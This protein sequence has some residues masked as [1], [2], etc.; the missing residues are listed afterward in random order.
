MQISDTGTFENR[1]ECNP[2]PNPDSD[3]KSNHF[4][5]PNLNPKTDPNPNIIPNPKAC[6][7]DTNQEVHR[8]DDDCTFRME[9]AMMHIMS[10]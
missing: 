7:A 6:S 5:N 2:N 4:H 3:P 9:A 1:R 8:G 10:G